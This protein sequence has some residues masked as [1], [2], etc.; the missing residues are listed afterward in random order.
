M[1][2]QVSSEYLILMAV[3]LVAVL[4]SLAAL[5]K[6]A[7][8]S[9]FAF[10]GGL[11]RA[12]AESVYNTGEELCALG[13]GSSLAIDVL[14]GLNISYSG[15]EVE[16]YGLNFS[17]FNNSKTASCEWDNME[18]EK[19]KHLLENENGKIKINPTP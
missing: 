19:G 9:R 17:G 14:Y 5:S 18:M 6:G 1:R 15:P 4:I 8:A 3:G 2:A 16:M 11:F 13:D 7:E 12:S 10:D